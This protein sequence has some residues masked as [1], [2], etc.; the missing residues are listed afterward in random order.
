MAI[1]GAYAP[2]VDGSPRFCQS[3][4]RLRQNSSWAQLMRRVFAIDV[5][6]CSCGGK[7]RVLA[8]IHPP[9]ATVKILDCLGLPSR[10]PPL[11]PARITED[12]AF[13]P[14]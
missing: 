14:D 5:L 3:P 6:A 2:D 11:A 1:D 9:D 8:A 10:P 13:A 4:E 12:F 7:L